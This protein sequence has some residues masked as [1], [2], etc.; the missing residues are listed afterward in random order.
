MSVAAEAGPRHQKAPIFQL[1]VDAVHGGGGAGANREARSEVAPDV[2]LAEEDDR[3]V[4]FGG[5]GGER[6]GPRVV[7]V[8]IQAGVLRD[9]RG[10]GAV[11]HGLRRGG[12]CA[13]AEGDGGDAFAGRVREASGGAEQL[14]AD[15]DELAGFVFYEDEDA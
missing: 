2:G 6:G 11:G 14:L 12:R 5:G 3:G 8:F 15:R 13:A 4:D 9:K 10:V 7:G 1:K